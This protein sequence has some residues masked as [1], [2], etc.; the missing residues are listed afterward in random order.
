[1][2]VSQTVPFGS[3]RS[4]AVVVTA[5]IDGDTIA[6]AKSGRIRLLGIDAPEAGRGFD[7]EAPFAREARERLIELVLRRWVRLEQDGAAFDVYKRR[8]A[9]VFREDGL[10]VN[11]AMVRDGLAR[12][13]AREPLARLVELKRAEAEAKRARRGMWGA[14]PRMLHPGY[15]R[16]PAC[17]CPFLSSTHPSEKFGSGT[18]SITGSTTGRS[19]FSSFLSRRG[20]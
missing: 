20:R 15:T 10:F 5:V 13:T 19:G 6:V 9:Y 1:M 17:H 16:E 18:N 8:L 3:K 11:A 4:E 14:A 12:V 2:A 7:T